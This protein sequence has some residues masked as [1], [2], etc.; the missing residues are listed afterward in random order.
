MSHFDRGRLGTRQIAPTDK[1]HLSEY[2]LKLV[3][4]TAFQTT[5]LQSAFCCDLWV[6]AHLPASSEQGT[7]SS[8][9]LA[10]LLCTQPGCPQ[11]ICKKGRPRHL[12]HCLNQQWVLPAHTAEAALV[13]A[14]G[15]HKDGCVP[16]TGSQL[17]A[18]HKNTEI[19]LLRILTMW[20][21]LS[22]RFPF[23]SERQ[24]VNSIPF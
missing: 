16:A 8:H 6:S 20:D 12:S 21:V 7:S 5:G 19:P 10:A 22:F 23:W 17:R 18:R 13:G 11:V 2:G 1:P 3:M 9:F 15:G 14:A 24:G 4:H